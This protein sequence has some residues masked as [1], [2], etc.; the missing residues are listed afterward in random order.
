MKIEYKGYKV[1]ERLIADVPAFKQLWMVPIVFEGIPMKGY[2]LFTSVCA[3]PKQYIASNKNG[4][5]GRW[6]CT[7]E[8]AM[9][10]VPEYVNKR[11]QIGNWFKNVF[12]FKPR[13]A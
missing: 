1:G 10:N 5:W 4:K 8:Q 6:T 12:N 3:N 2:Y 13:A 9:A 7:P 11:N